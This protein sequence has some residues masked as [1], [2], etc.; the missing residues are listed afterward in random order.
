MASTPYRVPGPC[1]YKFGVGGVSLG[2]SKEGCIIRARTS[3]L[4]IIDDSHGA[5]PADF[6][7]G[8]ESAVVEIIGL[9]MEQM[10]DAAVFSGAGGLYLKDYGSA[11]VGVLAS[12]LATILRVTERDGGANYWEALK[13]IPLDP[14]VL[15]L[16]S[17]VE[18][19]APVS[20]LIL[21]DDN[22]K[23][24]SHVPSYVT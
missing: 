21:P 14:D 19:Q 5:E 8:G 24:F 12:A 4:P 10:Y 16:K 23:L 7:F 6:I 13:T 9:H 2:H 11:Y 22:D 15:A 20:F 3:W 18:L 1:T 17:T